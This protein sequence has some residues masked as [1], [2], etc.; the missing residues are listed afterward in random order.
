VDLKK[1]SPRLESL[2]LHSTCQHGPVGKHVKRKWPPIIRRAG[3]GAMAVLLLLALAPVQ[4]DA[5]LPRVGGGGA[6]V[7]SVGSVG[8]PSLPSV[9]GAG[10]G[11]GLPGS[12]SSFPSVDDNSIGLGVRI[13]TDFGDGPAA[14]PRADPLRVLPKPGTIT[15]T[16]T[17]PSSAVA[18]RPAQPRRSGVPAA[19]ERRFV[20]DEVVVRL[21]TN[22]S[23][24][25]L[26]DLARRHRLTRLESQSIG[27]TGTTF[28]RWRI[29]D[30]RPVSDVIRALET[31]GAV[32]AAQPNY[33]FALQQSE[34]QATAEVDAM[35]YAPAKLRLQEAHQFSTGDKILIAIIDSGIDA[36]HLEIAGMVVESFDAV[37]SKQ[38]PD[39]HGTAMAGAII[40]HVRLKGIAPAAHILAVRAFT[41]TE[42]TTLTILKGI[43]WAVARGA[44]IINMSFAGPNDPE[45]AR[46]LAAARQK[47]VI[48]VAAAGNAG[49]KSAPLYP[50]ADSNVI[51]V[52]ATDA[53]DNLFAS[54]NRGRHIAVAAPGVDILGP[55]PGGGYQLSTGTSVAA[56]HVSGVAALLLALKPTLTPDAVRKLLL[57]TA[58]DLG[59]KGR[60]DQFGAG[61]ADAYGAIL[62]LNAANANR[63][64][65]ADVSA[66]R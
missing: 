5:Q 25:A 38:G 44:R 29:T 60:D 46:G 57:A 39:R 48:L 54:A 32:G 17:N 19:G 7:G 26:D 63:V 28:H 22:L 64:K 34:A 4:A 62:S 40:A 24:Q 42:G 3:V 15:N 10:I 27:L 52:T 59:P 11:S 55:A 9:G 43:D 45:I 41:A 23:R 1:A 31:D 49:A 50:A 47:G 33:R 2:A 37:N 16:I 13:P 36:S 6:G 58:T 35:Q 56:A 51:A 61:L 18:G 30:Q 8:A 12:G 14:L 65:P 53:H 66:A 20:P 21:P